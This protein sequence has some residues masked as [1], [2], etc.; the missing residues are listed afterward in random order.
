VVH[1]LQKS[2]SRRCEARQRA[3]VT[4]FFVFRVRPSSAFLREGEVDAM[5]GSERQLLERAL[6]DDAT[7]PV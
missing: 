6:P 7:H 2:S 4:R 1:R 3:L 5:R